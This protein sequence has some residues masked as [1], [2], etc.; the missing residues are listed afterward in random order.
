MAVSGADSLRHNYIEVSAI[1]QQKD[2]ER[3]MGGNLLSF[4]QKDYFAVRVMPVQFSH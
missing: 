4:T 2:S 3:T 1:Q